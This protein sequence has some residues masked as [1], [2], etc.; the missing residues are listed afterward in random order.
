MAVLS[1]REVMPRTFQQ[2]FG[3]SPTAERKFVATLDEP[4][5]TQQIISQ[6]GILFGSQHPEFPYLRMLDGSV[7]ETDRQHAEVTYRYELPQQQDLDPNPLARP[8]VWSFSIGGAQVPALFYFHGNANDDVRPL[9]TAAGDFIEGLTATEAE[10]RANISSNR[11]AFDLVLASNIAN[12]INGSAYLGGPPFTW[13]CAGISG[14]QAAEVVNDVEIRYWQISVELVFRRSGWVMQIPHVGW[15][16]IEGNQKRRVWAWNED[17][18]QKV[19][20]AAPQ[21]LTENGGLKYPGADGV[22]DQL[23]RRTF[24]VIDFSQYFGTPP[25]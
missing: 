15:H 23:L 10:V 12:G 3:E 7:N 19:D 13:Q 1:W 14:N 20:A 11:P 8:D 5:P 22:P 6:I 2:R 21:P 17:G 9:V 25:F 18:T 4:T 16:F 24:P